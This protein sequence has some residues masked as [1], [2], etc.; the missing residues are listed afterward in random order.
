MVTKEGDRSVQRTEGG[1]KCEIC[2]QSAG[3]EAECLVCG[4]GSHWKCIGM[5]VSQ[6][7]GNILWSCPNC[8]TPA[9]P[10]S[11]DIVSLILSLHKK[12]NDLQKLPEEVKNLKK[13]MET[14]VNLP[15][16][17]YLQSFLGGKSDQDSVFQPTS[18]HQLQRLSRKNNR[19]DSV[20]STS[21]K[22]RK[23][24]NNDDPP[25]KRI[26]GIKK[27][28]VGDTA[29]AAAKRPP[30]RRHIFLSRVSEESNIETITSYCRSNN[31]PLSH[32]R[33]TTKEGWHHKC[34]HLIFEEKFAED[35]MEEDFWPADIKVG[36]FYLNDEARKWLKDLTDSKHTSE[37]I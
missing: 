30:G 4:A 26:T 35:I 29:F 6:F 32:I 36:R 11:G 7:V 12:V 16:P 5:D 22:K 28:P 37:P 8:V 20:G 23:G 24:S 27:L 34:F 1:G 17:T 9:N 25:A 31:V 3:K 33:E 18:S 13:D 2:Y 10:T 19:T 14:F 21:S 15:K